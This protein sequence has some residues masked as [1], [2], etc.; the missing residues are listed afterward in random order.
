MAMSPI[1]STGPSSVITRNDL[2]RTP[3]AY[4]VR[5]TMLQALA[6]GVRSVC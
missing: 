6:M 2:A 4:S 1:I 3:S 5:A